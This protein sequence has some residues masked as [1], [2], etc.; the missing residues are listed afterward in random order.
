LY[1][2][3][4]KL[5]LKAFLIEGTIGGG[6]VYGKNKKSLPINGKDQVE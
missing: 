3:S 2:S 1:F 5:S 4:V 6:L